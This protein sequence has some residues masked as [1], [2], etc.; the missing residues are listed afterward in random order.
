MNELIALLEQATGRPALR[1]ELPMQPG[2]VE[3]TFADAAKLRGVTGYE[4][5]TPLAQGLQ[6]FVQWYRA[7]IGAM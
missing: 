1:N 2:D 5:A 7:Y 4:P 6:K 3:R